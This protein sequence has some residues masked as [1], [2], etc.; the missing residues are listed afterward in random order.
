MNTETVMV[1]YIAFEGA[2]ARNER[3]VKRLIIALII[4]ISLMF[5]SNGIWLYAWLQYD[6]AYDEY[7]VEVDTE[8]GGDA[9][10]IGRDG[11]I[12]NGTSASD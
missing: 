8:E 1:P 2:M 9:N 6:Y 5:A 10:Y 12:Y 7:T 3:I 11:G 4:A